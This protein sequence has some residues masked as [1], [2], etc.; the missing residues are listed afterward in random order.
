[1]TRSAS[2]DAHE[3]HHRGH[4]TV[5]RPT[6]LE[7]PSAPLHSSAKCRDRDARPRRDRPRTR[8]PP[9]ACNS[10]PPP[11]LPDPSPRRRPHAPFPRFAQTKLSEKMP[12]TFDSCPGA[13]PRVKA[14]MADVEVCALALPRAQRGFGADSASPTTPTAQ[15]VPPNVEKM[16]DNGMS[17]PDIQEEVSSTSS[18]SRTPRAL[19]ADDRDVVQQGA[20]RLRLP[21]HEA[22]VDPPAAQWLDALNDSGIV[23]FQKHINPT[24]STLTCASSRRSP[25]STT[26]STRRGRVGEGDAQQ[27]V[28]G[29]D[30]LLDGYPIVSLDTTL[31]IATAYKDER[32]RDA[33]YTVALCPSA[34]TTAR[35]STALALC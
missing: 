26:S 15:I 4:T 35:A 2:R 29:R 23:A 33:L 20:R 30:Y 27:Q 19:A 5:R 31:D 17:M 12:K 10:P 3:A 22:D 8:S 13:T 16:M 32:L 7:R 1:M 6:A 9:S 14:L 18:C 11:T 21:D 28:E 25:A 34:P 24:E